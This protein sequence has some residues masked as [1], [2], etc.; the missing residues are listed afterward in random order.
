MLAGRHGFGRSR[1]LTTEEVLERHPDARA[2]G[3]ARRRAVPR[4]AVRRQP[5]A[6]R[7]GAD[8]RRAGRLPGQL[9][10]GGRAST[11]DGD[12]YVSG[13]VF[14]DLETGREHTVAAR[15]VINATG[16]FCDGVRQ[17]GRSRRAADDRAQPGRPH[18]PA[19]S[20]SSAATRRSWCRARA[21]RRVMFAIP[22][23]DHT[24]VGTTDTPDRARRRSSRGRSPR[25]STSS[26]RPRAATCRSN[27]TP[28]RRAQR[29]RRH[30][31]AGEGG[32]RR[33]HGGAV[34]RAHDPDQQV[35]PAHDRRRQVDDLPQD[36]RGLRQPRGHAR[37][38]RRAAVR[39]ARPA[40]PRLPPHRPP[41]FGAFADY[42]AD[43]PA[44]AG[45]RRGSARPRR[46]ARPG[47]ARCARRR[48]SGPCATRWR[49]R[50][51]DVLARRTR[52][53]SLNARA[54][55]RMAPA[56]ARLMAAELGRDDAWQHQ[57]LAEFAAIAEGYLPG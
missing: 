49:A 50:V 33:Q 34:A 55:L 31:A 39:H 16:A 45:S 48:W 8:G 47:A 32:R 42:G 43:A 38:P 24:V 57:Q 2:G 28:L 41:Q 35:G 21:T 36:G 7:P 51:D 29:V 37:R 26:S 19:T 5:A 18:R 25:R 44:L 3:P 54:A 23:H 15:C 22:W 9:R 27:P 10:A 4:R 14:R 11:K 13:A 1:I 56:V 40:H 52:A 20:A 17:H 46:R 53:L 12:G 6:D 30:P